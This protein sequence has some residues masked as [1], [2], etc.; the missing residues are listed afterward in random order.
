[1]GVAAQVTDLN[2]VRPKTLHKTYKKHKYVITYIVAT[3]KWKWEVEYV[4]VTTFSDIANTPN[5]AMRAAEK[6]IDRTL[7]IRGA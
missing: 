2:T 4:S 7:E 6:H 5:A 3:K 1:M